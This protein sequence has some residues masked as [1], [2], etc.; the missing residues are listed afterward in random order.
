MRINRDWKKKKK[1]A[2]NR[3]R[4]QEDEEGKQMEET[5]AC[6]G[7][8]KWTRMKTYSRKKWTGRETQRWLAH[9]EQMWFC[10]SFEKESGR[11]TS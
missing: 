9:T 4:G 7:Y 11:C 8:R 6:V 1:T 2:S 3:Y 10:K 5:E